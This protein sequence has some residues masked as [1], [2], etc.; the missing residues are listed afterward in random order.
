[1]SY[2]RP[3]KLWRTPN[4][5]GTFPELDEKKTTRLKER[6]YNYCLWAL[7]S[8][9][10]TRKELEDKMRV[11]NCTEEIIQEILDKV[12]DMGYLDDNDYAESYKRYKT[13]ANW[14]NSKIRR[15]LSRKGISEEILN[16]VFP[17]ER[18]EEDLDEERE[19]A[20]TLAKKKLR[21]VKKDLERRKKSD[22]LV[23]ALSRAGF[24]LGVAFEVV[25]A[26]LDEEN[27][28]PEY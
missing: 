19:R 14:G 4:E 13:S 21:S 6:A 25:K 22:R 3:I 17:A 28:V 23:G 24:P 8:S 12:T 2:G 1:M 27:E 26:V 5:D 9:S 16:E 11:K 20:Y 18:T 15:E 10:K 7:G